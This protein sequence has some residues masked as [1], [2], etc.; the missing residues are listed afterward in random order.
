MAWTSALLLALSL[1][2]QSFASL[3]DLTAANRRPRI[4]GLPD[5]TQVG[6]EQGQKPLPDD[7]LVAKTVT[8]AQLA[9]VY[10]VAPNDGVDDTDG[11]QK[12]ING[13]PKSPQSQSAPSYESSRK[14]WQ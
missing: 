9:S 14:R 2:P 8:A 12:A 4:P 11:L 10:G 6:Y 7:S 3:I 1:T 5:W 13:I